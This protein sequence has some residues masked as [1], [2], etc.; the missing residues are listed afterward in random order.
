LWRLVTYQERDFFP[1]IK[2]G[3]Q[4]AVKLVD[5]AIEVADYILQKS[6]QVADQPQ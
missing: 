3:K 6:G 2:R 4:P 1:Q 5:V